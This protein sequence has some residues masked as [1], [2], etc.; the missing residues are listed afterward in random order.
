VD[1]QAGAGAGGVLVLFAEVSARERQRREL[2]ERSEENERLREL[3]RRMAAEAD[4]VRLLEALCAAA[5]ALCDA[6]GA[7]VAQVGETEGRFVAALGHPPH[8]GQHVFPLAGTLS[9]RLRDA[10]RATGAASPLRATDAEARDP[11]YCGE[12]ADGRTVGALLLAPLAAQGDLLGVLAISRAEGRPAFGERDTQRLRVVADHASLALWKARLVDA[13]QAATRTAST[14][15]ATVSHELRT[16]LTALTGYGEL[17]AD[18]ILGPLSADQHDVV[19]RMRGVTHQLT[20]MIEEILT[21]S[22]LEAGKELV[23][24]VPVDVAEIVDSVVTILEPLARQKGLAFTVEVPPLPPPLVTDPDKVRQI[25]VN[26]GGNAVKFT[27]AGSVALRVAADGAAVRVAVTD[28]GVG[29]APEDAGRLFRPFSQLDAGLTRRY[30]G[31][32]LGL[33]ISQRLAGLLGGKVEF[34]PAE[35]RGSVFTLTLPTG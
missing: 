29:I 12:L 32:G 23:R 30:G 14:F 17:L 6:D 21:F 1:E 35:G 7:T 33:Y 2:A 16:P 18:E 34:A 31:T 9:G 24:P 3:A 26:L 11:A 27:P 8:V 20:A 15:L 4:S 13:A 5:R 22:S 19:E 25:L 28:T 10:F